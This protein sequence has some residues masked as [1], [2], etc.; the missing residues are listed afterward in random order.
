MNV[1]ALRG[2]ENTVHRFFEVD[3]SYP[4][5]YAVERQKRDPLIASNPGGQLFFFFFPPK[6]SCFDD[7]I[8]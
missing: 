3:F 5:K 8:C 1:E 6:N 2:E 4:L 7:L